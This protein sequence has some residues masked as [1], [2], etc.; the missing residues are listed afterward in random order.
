MSIYKKIPE[1]M[2]A[3]GA[4][5]KTRTNT[6]GAGYRFRGID[7]CYL[8]LQKPLADHGVFFVPEVLSSQ[9]EERQSKAGGNLIYTILS[10]KY[11]FFA[12]DGS[13]IE[14]IVP[15]EAMD[16][17]DKSSNKAMSAA[18]KLALLQLFCIP[19]EEDKDTE[20][21]SHE[22]TPRTSP[23]KPKE[24]PISQPVAA[25]E[26]PTLM[27]GWQER[28]EIA[29]LATTH[30]WKMSDVTAHM[31]Q[32]YGKEQVNQLTLAQAAELADYI[33]KKKG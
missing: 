6:Q 11:S 31:K 23:V 33:E 28:T 13:K 1:I 9:R 14:L 8:A 15:G 3:V 30:Q 17:G 12:D 32:K 22:V 26:Q 4:I 18:L 24:Q 2:N 19:T 27:A 7:D 29:Q 10:V 5:A 16:S 25:N 21:H 20:N